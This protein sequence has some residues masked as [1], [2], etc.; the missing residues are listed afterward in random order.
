MGRLTTNQIRLLEWLNREDYSQL[1]ACF[2]PDLKAL[3]D[4]GY[5]QVFPPDADPLKATYDIVSSTVRGRQALK[6]ANND[7]D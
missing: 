5:A 7:T 1:G 6:E 3:V 4:A 2:G